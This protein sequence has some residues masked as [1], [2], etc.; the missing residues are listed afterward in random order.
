MSTV[1]LNFGAINS[2]QGID[3]AATVSQ[4][5]AIQQAVETPW[6]NQLTNLRGQD[7]ALS[8]IGTDLSTLSTSLRALTDFSGIFASKQ[9]SSSD[10]NVVV[11]T[12]ATP[13]ASA[14]SHSITVNSLAQTSSIYSGSVA[15][16][17]DTLNGTLTIQVGSGTQSITI[18]S[19]NNTLASL[20]AAINAASMGVRAGVIKDTSGSRL[21]LVSA[22]SGAGGQI[23]LTSSISDTTTGSA[24]SFQQGQQGKDASLNIDG[25]DVT[26][27]SNT[28]S[29]VIPGVTFQMLTTS[30]SARPVQV[31]ITND[32]NSIEQAMSAFATAYNAVV[33]DIKAQ[34]GKDSSGNAKP[35]YGDPTLALIQNQL[36][37]G[38]LGGQASGAINNLAQLGLSVGQDGKLTL[39]TGDL[40]T[41]LNSNFADVVGFLQNTGSFGQTLTK[42]LNGLS[43]TLT[44]GAIYLALQQNS[45][46]EAA[47]NDNIS[48]QE[49]RIAADKVRLT[50]QLNAANQILQ[51]LPDQLNQIDQMYN[52]VTGYTRSNG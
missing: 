28:V 46:Q 52:A 14:G 7:S 43:S 17:G 40:E 24:I 10:T 25:L 13:V 27:S 19:S 31:Q 15:N 44:S 50:A 12:S 47:L 45:A 23:T 16:A 26:T 3:V 11:L 37:S 29:D 49:T 48:D 5:I 21:S 9:G 34:Q 18:G 38:L 42:A 20:A 2:G 22:T 39:N 32:N 35:L 6:K 8:S 4:I 30:V 41:S 33:T 36:T 51:S 1:G